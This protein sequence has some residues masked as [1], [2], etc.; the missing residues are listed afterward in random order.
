[1]LPRN[2]ILARLLPTLALSSGLY[3]LPAH[4]AIHP[5]PVILN[6]FQIVETTGFPLSTY[7]VFSTNSS[8]VAQPIPFQIDELNE[9]GDFILDQGPLHNAGQSNGRFD[10]RDELAVMGTDVGSSTPPSNWG[11]IPK[12]TYLFE[13]RLNL[14]KGDSKGDTPSGAI[15]VGVYLHRLPPSAI[16]K[17]YVQFQEAQNKITTSRYRY[18][19]DPTNYLV[20]QGVDMIRPGTGGETGKPPEFI[21]LLKSSSAYIKADLKYFLTFEVGDKTIQSKLESYKIGPVRGIARV[22]FFYSFLKINIKLDMYT[23]ISFFSNA[24]ILPAILYSPIDGTRRLNRGSGFYYGFAMMDNP[25]ALKWETNLPEYREPSALA[26]LL[27]GAPRPEPLY[28]AAATASDKMMYI[29][30]SLSRS[31]RQAGILPT[32]FKSSVAGA[33]MKPSQ[34]PQPLGKAPV[35][36]ALFFDLTRFKDGEH[37]M[38]FRIFFE[39]HFEP[40]LLDTYRKLSRWQVD[41]TKL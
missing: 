23:E 2:H 39:N 18:R 15:Y 32:L 22:G 37:F 38:G 26:D 28:W 20:T 30:L 10:G 24:V 27:E 7:R 35:N 31:M 5:A 40:S 3:C 8:G 12:P 21:P 6:A 25:D 33:S 4:G 29:E 34:T 16:T 14:P 17:S 13:V 41:V 11:G 1:L 36:M 19:F 9:I